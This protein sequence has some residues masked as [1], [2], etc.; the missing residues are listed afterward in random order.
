[1]RTT[2]LSP[3]AKALP[4][5][6]VEWELTEDLH[7]RSAIS[8]I[9]N[10]TFTRATIATG[11]SNG[12][13]YRVASGE[14]RYG[15]KNDALGVLIEGARTNAISY[16]EQLDGTGWLNANCTITSNTD[17]SPDGITTADT[18]TTTGTTD[19]R[20]QKN[21]SI[22]ADTTSYTFSV[23]LKK[24]T[25]K[26]QFAAVRMS[27]SGG[28]VKFTTVVVNENTGTITASSSADAS[29]TAV[30]EYWRVSITDADNGTNTILSSQIYPGY[31]LNGSINSNFQSGAS[32]V[33]WGTQLENAAFP[34]SYIPTTSAVTRNADI[35]SY[36]L[37][38]W[39]NTSEG[40]IVCDVYVPYVGSS[41]SFIFSLDDGTANEM[42]QVY[43]G[44]GTGL[45]YNIV[46]GG[47]SQVAISSASKF[48]NG[49][50]SKIAIAWKLNDFA[51]YLDG[52]QIGTDAAGTLP[53]VTTLRISTD[54]AGANAGYQNIK[55]IRYYLTR[56][57]NAD[58][59]RLTR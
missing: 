27:F 39:F 31:N 21:I 41:N 45:N 46:D 15:A 4:L 51:I 38:S 25:A 36:S 54:Q 11:D 58:L 5:P 1:M 52:T 30:G 57:S 56:L 12:L 17:V 49:Q 28:T 16:S 44:S 47:V 19:P 20:I 35:L 55:N 34:S 37:G 7:G 14:P 8:G 22:S 3:K 43:R 10:G 29:I 32:S 42:I 50:I 13:I 53:T 24:Q 9:F 23:Y 6:N 26:I 2:A 18:I 59:V 33:A 40:T 48:A